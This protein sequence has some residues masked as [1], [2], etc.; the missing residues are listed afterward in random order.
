MAT[1]DNGSWQL[2]IVDDPPEPADAAVTPDAETTAQQVAALVALV[3]EE[4]HSIIERM[5]AEMTAEQVRTLAIAM[6]R[7][8]NGTENAN[9]EVAD[10]GPDGICAIAIAT[11]VQAFGTSRDAVLSADR[12]RPVSDA[13]AVAMTAARRSGLT[14]PSIASYFGMNHTSVMYAQSKVANNPRLNAVCVR[15]VDEL[16]VHCADRIVLKRTPSSGRA[17]TTPTLQLEA[18]QPATDHPSPPRRRQPPVRSPGRAP[19]R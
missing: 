12:H 16:D 15:I 14:L 9:G 1:P 11:A 2:T 6:A 18:G 8:V 7:Q 13:R 10:V 17:S 4:N 19:G 3:A 5:L